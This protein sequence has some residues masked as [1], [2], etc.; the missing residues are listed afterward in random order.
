ML[1]FV[2]FTISSAWHY[3][4]ENNVNDMCAYYSMNHHKLNTKKSIPSLKY[5]SKQNEDTTGPQEGVCNWG[6]QLAGGR[7]GK[8]VIIVTCADP[9]HGKNPCYHDD[10]YQNP[11]TKN[12]SQT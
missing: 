3:I 2:F 4:F 7:V 11:Y 1:S 8:G 12:N 9:V 10:S 5:S 6:G